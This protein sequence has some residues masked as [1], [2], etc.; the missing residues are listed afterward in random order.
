VHAIFSYFPQGRIWPV[1]RRPL[2]VRRGIEAVARAL[3]PVDLIPVSIHLEPL[4]DLRPT[5]FLWIG[6]PISVDPSGDATTTDHIEA[7]LAL[8]LDRIRERLD[9]FGEDVSSAWVDA[10]GYSAPDLEPQRRHGVG[11]RSDRSTGYVS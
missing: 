6:P 1:T 9:H 3:A 5:P 7:C 2:G 8:G 10:D 11:R 4:A